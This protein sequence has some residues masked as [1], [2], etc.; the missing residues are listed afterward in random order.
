MDFLQVEKIVNTHA[1]QGEVKVL[2]ESDF[3]EDRFCIGSEL[4]IDFNGEHIPVVV[5]SHRS[6]KGM[7][8]LK[9]KGINSINDVELYKGSNLLVSTEYLKDLDDDEFY[10][11][12]I[13]GCV[14]KSVEGEVIGEISDV[15]RTGANDVWTV[16]R[17]GQK[18]VLVPYIEQVVKTV[19]IHEKEVVIE[20][21]DGLLV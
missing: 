2:S 10:Y 17:E 11:F 9:F 4:V 7:D 8:L 3:K 20:I 16:K 5:A 12:E 15:L 6:H 14:V 18:D 13:I 19:N 21:V 1:L